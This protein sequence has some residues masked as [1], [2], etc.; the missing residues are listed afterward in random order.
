MFLKFHIQVPQLFTTLQRSAQDWGFTHTENGAC[1]AQKGG[2]C[3]CPRFKNVG[4]C[5]TGNLLYYI[6]SIMKPYARW[7][8]DFN[9]PEWTTDEILRYFK[10]SEYNENFVN[11]WHAQCGSLKVSLPVTPPELNWFATAG[12]QAN[13]PVNWREDINDNYDGEWFST[14]QLTQSNGRY[15]HRYDNAFHIFYMILK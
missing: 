5:S 15:T 1:K 8:T 3:Y 10:K 12:A 2:K 4:G 9:L 6:R 11:E 7:S 14:I 13:P